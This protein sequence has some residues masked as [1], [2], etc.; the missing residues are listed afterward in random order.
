MSR[1][2]IFAAGLAHVFFCHLDDAAEE[3]RK[4]LK[5]AKDVSV[6]TDYIGQQLTLTPLEIIAKACLDLRIRPDTAKAIFDNYDRFL[7]ILDDAK[8]RGEL[9]EAQTHQD[10]RESEVWKQVGAVSRPFHEGL[11]AL[12][13]RDD[14]RLKALTMEYGVWSMEYGVF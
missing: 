2:L 13:L 6:L 10:L 14:E 11:V 12:F 3:A 7:A 8:K 5:D 1:K 9:G 4:A